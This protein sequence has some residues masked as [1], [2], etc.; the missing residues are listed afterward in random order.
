MSYLRHVRA[1][2]G[3]VCP[4]TAVEGTDA[5]RLY[6]CSN[7][8]RLR[9]GN[10]AAF[11]FTSNDSSKQAL[12]PRTARP[13]LA[14]RFY[15]EK[16]EE[17]IVVMIFFSSHLL[18]PTPRTNTNLYYILLFRFVLEKKGKGAFLCPF[19]SLFFFLLK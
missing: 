13:Y 10:R 9:T 14:R 16:E 15:R 7:R 4:S 8:T 11:Y 3:H 1:D 18:F 2:K 19:F 6:T 17:P 5:I 12:C